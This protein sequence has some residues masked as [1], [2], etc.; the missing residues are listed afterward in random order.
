MHSSY[1]QNC[2]FLL[3]EYPV[4]AKH[5]VNAKK[6]LV[7]V[8]LF[9]FVFSG[10]IRLVDY[11]NAPPPI[12]SVYADP[13]FCPGALKVTSKDDFGFI[14]NCSTIS[15]GS[16]LDS[17]VVIQ[18]L[19]KLDTNVYKV[20]AVLSGNRTPDP[21]VIA[22]LPSFVES[23]VVKAFVSNALNVTGTDVL[24]S[25][26]VYWGIGK[27]SKQDLGLV[28]ALL[29]RGLSNPYSRFNDSIMKDL[30]KSELTARIVKTSPDLTITKNT[31]KAPVQEEDTQ[32][33]SVE[34]EQPSSNKCLENTN[35]SPFCSAAEDMVEILDGPLVKIMMMLFIMGV[36]FFSVVSP[37]VVMFAS[38]ILA[39][40]FLANASKIASTIL[41]Y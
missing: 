34:P 2:V 9:S 24:D 29:E 19:S 32:T 40:L 28:S 26:T 27:S 15:K 21:D 23:D 16:E 20:V 6:F 37:N 41:G 4:N 13:E 17:S 36:I 12:L 39:V 14:L 3:N 38:S 7:Y 11:L 1:V 10:I 18:K 25:G 5:L 33:I 22:T 31:E 35:G 8:L 30:V